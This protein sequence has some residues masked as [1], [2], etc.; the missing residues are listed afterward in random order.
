[1]VT[2]VVYHS[3]MIVKLDVKLMCKAVS[4]ELTTDDRLKRTVNGPPMPSHVIVS[5]CYACIETR[6][7]ALYI[8]SRMYA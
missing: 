1:M 4:S 6:G 3:I 2:A 7:N 5:N 8:I